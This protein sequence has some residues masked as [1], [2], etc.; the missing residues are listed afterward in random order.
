MVLTDGNVFCKV[1]YLA[2]DADASL[3]CE[4]PESEVPQSEETV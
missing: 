2:V 1:V 3:W 4:I